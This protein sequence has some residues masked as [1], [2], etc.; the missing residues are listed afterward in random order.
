MSIFVKN[1]EFCCYLSIIIVFLYIVL[2]AWLYYARGGR[3]IYGEGV[4]MKMWYMLRLVTSVVFLSGSFLPICACGRVEDQISPRVKTAAW[5]SVGT[6]YGLF[7]L[8]L[9]RITERVVRKTLTPISEKYAHMLAPLLGS[10]VTLPIVTQLF[11][12]YRELVWYANTVLFSGEHISPRIAQEILEDL[13]LYVRYL[14]S[15]KKMQGE[16]EHLLAEVLVK[17]GSFISVD[18]LA[19]K[20]SK[21]VETG[22]SYVRTICKKLD[23]LGLYSE[24]AFLLV[25][26]RNG[27]ENQSILE[28]EQMVLLQSLEFDT[29]TFEHLVEDLFG[30][31]ESY[32]AHLMRAIDKKMSL[33][34]RLLRFEDFIVQVRPLQ[35]AF[36][37]TSSDSK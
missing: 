28:N 11:L 24:H 10:A 22:E 3:I 33:C 34:Q 15:L 20:I 12:Q 2:L 37:V 6:V 1:I 26:L 25:S 17:S 4:M 18:S 32:L 8:G 14:D 16:M 7:A 29:V 35:N 36:S 30:Y 31:W 19:K 9:D 27:A 23:D 13:R 21:V 5:V